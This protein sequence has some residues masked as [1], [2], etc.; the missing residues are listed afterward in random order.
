MCAFSEDGISWTQV[1][2]PSTYNQV[3]FG[4]G[5][6]VA[7][8]A[9]GAVSVSFDGKEWYD[10]S[11]PVVTGDI[12][13]VTYAKGR[14]IIGGVDGVIMY[15]EDFETWGIATSNSTVRYVRQIV[16]AENR[17][18]A[19][20]YT[21]SGAGEIWVSN[22]GET[23]TVQQQMTVRLWCLN[24]NDGKLVTAGDSGS[25]YISDLGIVWLT[26][27]PELASGQYL[28]ERIVFTLSDGGKVIGDSVFIK[29]LPTTA[30]IV[31]VADTNYSTFKARAASLNSAETTP[32]MNGAIAWTYE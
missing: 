4:N 14:Y 31:G 26:K 15:T 28:W 18:Y 16:Y 23:W 19:A 25:V 24:Y 20:C 21:S 7:V 6:Y 8:G 5:R 10:R 32:S 22:D 3:T 29:E 2:A 1:N 12:R 17:Y 13:C 30:S 27:Q 9:G 11:N